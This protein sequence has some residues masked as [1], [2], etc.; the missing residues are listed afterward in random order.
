MDWKKIGWKIL[1]PPLWL[2]LLLSV[3]STAVLI[4]V[5][6]KRMGSFCPCRR[7]LRRRVLHAFGALYLSGQNAAR[8]L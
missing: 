4:A 3:V 8:A 6:P 1:F 5:F 2:I 7:H